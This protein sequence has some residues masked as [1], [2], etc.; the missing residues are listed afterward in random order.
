[1]QIS[2]LLMGIA[3]YHQQKANSRW[4]EHI[5]FLFHVN[6]FGPT[7]ILLDP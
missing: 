2:L 5:G 3:N 1:M 4:F 6:S 7:T